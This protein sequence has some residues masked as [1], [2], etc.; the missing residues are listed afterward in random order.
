MSTYAIVQ[1]G[2]H[3]FKA[4]PGQVVTL[5]KIDGEVGSKVS[6][7]QVL[8]VSDGSALKVGSDLKATVTAEIMSQVKGKK[9]VVFKKKRRQ[10]YKRTQGHRQQYTQLKIETIG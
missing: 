1:V 4:I 2:S 10:G 9:V 3:Q 7:N 8:A 5:E 6:F